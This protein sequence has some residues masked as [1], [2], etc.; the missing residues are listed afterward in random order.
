MA[1]SGNTQAPTLDGELLAAISNLVVGI[2]ADRLGRGPTRARSY[3]ANDVVIC[4]MEDTMQKAE[5]TLLECG[6]TDT[7]ADVRSRYQEVMR[8]ELC[9]GI[10]RLTHRH[11]RAFIS[12]N[13][14]DPDICSELFVL[15]GPPRPGS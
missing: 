12:G 6:A 2:Y 13:N 11:V 14:S 1:I 9:E 5:R 3:I 8:R 4:L 15:D 7:L 10:E